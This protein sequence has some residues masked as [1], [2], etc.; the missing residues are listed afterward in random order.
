LLFKTDDGG[1][2]YLGCELFWHVRCSF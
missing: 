1:G 2:N